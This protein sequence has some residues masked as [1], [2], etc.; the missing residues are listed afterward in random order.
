M[1]TKHR[2]REDAA[3][4]GTLY[5][6]EFLHHRRG[7]ADLVPADLTE[8]CGQQS[9]HAILE[10]IRRISGRGPLIG[11]EIDG[12]KHEPLPGQD[13]GCGQGRRHSRSIRCGISG[14]SAGGIG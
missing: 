13:F 2:R 8:P 1:L 9:I 3:G 12:R 4:A 5:A 14:R 11:R 7:A 10:I 6:E